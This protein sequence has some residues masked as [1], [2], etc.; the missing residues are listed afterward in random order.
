[1]VSKRSASSILAAGV[2]RW[3]Q[4]ARIFEINR[5]AFVVVFDEKDVH[6]S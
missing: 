5:P 1:M 2:T 6:T 3:P 4:P